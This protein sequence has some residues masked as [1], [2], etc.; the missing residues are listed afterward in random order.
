MCQMEKT[1][2]TETP[3]YVLP[4]GRPVASPPPPP[5][6]ENSRIGHG[7]VEKPILN[8][9]YIYQRFKWNL[10][11]PISLL[12]YI[13]AVYI[14][15]KMLIAKLKHYQ[16]TEWEGIRNSTNDHFHTIKL[17]IENCIRNNK[18]LVL[19]FISLIFPCVLRVK[20]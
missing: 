19:A 16:P 20:Y 11:F 8:T 10:Q 5:P 4:P 14:I 3:Q 7:N 2:F 15:F 12:S 9:C 13:Q 17:F 6:V 18:H 1:I